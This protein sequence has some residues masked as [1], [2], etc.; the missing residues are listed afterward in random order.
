VLWG[1]REEP[2]RRVADEIRALAAAAAE[3]EG[4]GGAGP[5]SADVLVDSVDVGSKAEVAAA[6]ARVLAKLGRA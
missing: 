4:G 6:A 3:G 2:L 1:R 5:I